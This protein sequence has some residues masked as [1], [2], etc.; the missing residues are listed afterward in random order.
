[1]I[2]VQVHSIFSQL[3]NITVFVKQKLEGFFILLCKEINE[4]FETFLETLSDEVKFL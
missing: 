3:Q 4:H 1:M 2:N